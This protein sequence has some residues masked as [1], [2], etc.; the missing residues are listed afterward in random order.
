MNSKYTRHSFVI[1]TH[2]FGN[3]QFLFKGSNCNVLTG[4]TTD[5]TK[6][7]R[8][9]S[10]E[11]ADEVRQHLISR[12]YSESDLIISKLCLSFELCNSPFMIDSDTG[13]LVNILDAAPYETD[14]E[15]SENYE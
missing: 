3:P 2:T 8:F 10:W 5:I 4:F 15:E 12:N 9:R 7:R 11:D 14:N 1:I 13:K 6:A